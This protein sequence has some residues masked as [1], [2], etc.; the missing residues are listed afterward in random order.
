M[1]TQEAEGRLPSV[2]WPEAQDAD[3]QLALAHE[4]EAQLALAHEAEA[5]EALFHVE[6]FHEALDC[7]AL[8]QLAASNI[9]PPDESETTYASRPAFGFG[10]SLTFEAMRP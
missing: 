7:A 9:L 3:A 1:L 2:V 6:L 4:A 8:A 5:H 10:G